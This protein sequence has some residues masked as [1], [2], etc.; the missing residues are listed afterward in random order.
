MV[1]DA[2][3]MLTMPSWFWAKSRR[4]TGRPSESHHRRDLKAICQF[5][6]RISTASAVLAL[7]AFS[8]MEMI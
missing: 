7:P 5:V 8:A 2:D 1:D 4:V 3:H 6:Y